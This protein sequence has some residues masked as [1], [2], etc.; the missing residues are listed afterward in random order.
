MRLDCVPNGPYFGPYGI[1]KTD[2]MTGAAHRLAPRP[3]GDAGRHGGGEPRGRVSRRR[4]RAGRDGLGRVAGRLQK[5]RHGAL[6]GGG[7]GARRYGG[8]WNSPGVPMVYT[9]ETLALA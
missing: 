1:S 8:R 2:P 5:P 7:G 6:A 9:S 4:A 3:A